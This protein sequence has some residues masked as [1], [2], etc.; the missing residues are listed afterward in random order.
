[1]AEMA[2]FIAAVNGVQTATQIVRFIRDADMALETADLKL[3]IADL[4]DALGDAKLSLADVRE[5]I[6][7]KEAE[8]QRLTEALKNKAAVAR[9]EDAYYELDGA[10]NLVGTPYCVHCFET[11]HELI[12]IHQNPDNRRQSFCPKCKTAV[13]WQSRIK[14][15]EEQSSFEPENP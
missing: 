12:A 9:H 3:K 5:I 14:P 6:E 7:S 13:H 11:R 2:A 10:E 4:V 1:M 15:K 8:I